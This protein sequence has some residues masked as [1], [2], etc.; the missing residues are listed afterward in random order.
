MR[1][2]VHRTRPPATSRLSLARALDRR[3]VHSG[4]REG[5]GLAE[6]AAL[7]IARAHGELMLL[8]RIER[9]FKAAMC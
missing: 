8:E 7:D 6:R 4:I 9:G 3:G 1:W 5:E 2:V